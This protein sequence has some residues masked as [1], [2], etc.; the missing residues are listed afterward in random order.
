MEEALCF[1]HDFNMVA[2]CHLPN[3]TCLFTRMR[4][5]MWSCPYCSR[6]NA[7]IWR[8]FLLNKLPNVADSWWLM[9]LTAHSA[10]R[11]RGQ[12]F[13]NIRSNIDRLMKRL[14]RTFGEFDYV[15]VY[16]KHPSSDAL[17]AHFIVSNL[18]PFVVHGHYKNGQRGF[19]GVL[20][21]PARTGTWSINSYVKAV[22]QECG[23]G[24]IADCRHV[25]DEPGRAVRYVTK[26]LTKE[27]QDI[28]IPYLRHV[29]TSRRIGSPKAESAH[30]WEVGVRLQRYQVGAEESVIDLNTGEV[31][32]PD[33]WREFEVYPPA[34]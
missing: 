5:N 8:A 12:S 28:G 20:Q 31:I 13:E 23:M 4:C 22:S 33:F 26:Y 24:Y 10:L 2:W 19:I 32:T 6:K 14:H 17:H 30:H 1:C 25:D 11:S 7:S 3:G 9:T 34:I 29:Q 16:E 18:S 15:R 21:K 27:Q